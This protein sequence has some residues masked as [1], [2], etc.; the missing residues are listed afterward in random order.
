MNLIYERVKLTCWLWRMN[1]S[2]YQSS[3]PQQLIHITT[4]FS[5]KK[6]A[7][8]VVSITISFNISKVQY[9][10]RIHFMIFY[11]WF[12]DIPDSKVIPRNFLSSKIAKNQNT[13][14][15]SQ[16]SQIK[17]RSLSR[18]KLDIWNI[19]RALLLSIAIG[20]FVVRLV[21]QT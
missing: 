1:K 15:I 2:R 19:R 5:K 3:H 9:L 14:F 18:I 12:S 4:P 16:S 10:D 11:L 6:G 8:E 20:S 17:S 21:S 13:S 7:V